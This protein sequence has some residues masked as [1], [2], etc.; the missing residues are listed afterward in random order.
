MEKEDEKGL[1][2]EFMYSM[3]PALEE[4]VK[5][6]TKKVSLFGQIVEGE[7]SAEELRA[8]P[9]ERILEIASE[10]EGVLEEYFD[11]EPPEEVFEEVYRTHAVKR[12]RLL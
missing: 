8:V 1:E 11:D 6:R 10:I 7:L 5:R 2:L 4:N 12:R 9:L 3:V